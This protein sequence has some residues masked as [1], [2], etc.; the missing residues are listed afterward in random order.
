MWRATNTTSCG[1]NF[2]GTISIEYNNVEYYIVTVCQ[3]DYVYKI[4]CIQPSR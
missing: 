1:K 2:V 4:L 3:L